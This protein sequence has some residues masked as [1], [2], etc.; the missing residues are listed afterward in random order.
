MNFY[1]ILFYFWQIDRKEENKK[2]QNKRVQDQEST[3]C[4][5]TQTFANCWNVLHQLYHLLLLLRIVHRFGLIFPLL[6]LSFI[7]NCQLP[8]TQKIKVL[9]YMN[10]LV[11]GKGISLQ[12]CHVPTISPNKPKKQTHYTQK[13]F[14]F[15][16]LPLIPF[17][18]LL[19][20]A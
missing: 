7:L 1:F 19:I 12:S 3:K 10:T 2:H 18:Q 4:N 8:C 11:A 17:S 20:H 13:Y 6:R 14:K 9:P 15:S 16:K 5:Q